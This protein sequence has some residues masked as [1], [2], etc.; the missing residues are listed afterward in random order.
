MTTTRNVRNIVVMKRE[1]ENQIDILLNK[2]LGELT[3][4]LNL[5]DTDYTV[6]N[7]TM[8]KTTDSLSVVLEFKDEAIAA[9]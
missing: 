1:E 5:K 6:Y 3:K 8:D 2:T 9:N 7:Y 4:L